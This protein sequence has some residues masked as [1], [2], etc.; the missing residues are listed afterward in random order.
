MLGGPFILHYNLDSTGSWGYHF[1]SLWTTP[2]PDEKNLFLKFADREICKFPYEKLNFFL[3]KLQKKFF[4][5]YTLPTQVILHAKFGLSSIILWLNQ[6]ELYLQFV[7]REIQ[8]VPFE[9]RMKYLL[10]S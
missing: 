3:D 1:G 6:K 2:W 9:M 5:S 8:K 4:S 10:F 7:I